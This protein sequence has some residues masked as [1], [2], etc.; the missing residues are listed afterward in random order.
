MKTTLTL[1][2]LAAFSTL[3][4]ADIF[5]S[6]Y[7]ANRIR[8]FDS[9]GADMGTFASISR[10]LGLRY[11]P[12]GTFYVASVSTNRVLE[13]NTKGQTIRTIGAG[14]PITAPISLAFDATVLY[15]SSLAT[16]QILKYSRSNG[17]YLGALAT[18]GPLDGPH[19]LAV[20]SAGNIVVA[21]MNNHSVLRYSN[22]GTLLGMYT[23]EQLD[24]P[25]GVATDASGKVYV[26]SLGGNKIFSLDNTLNVII[27]DAALAGPNDMLISGSNLYVNSGQDHSIRMYDLRTGLFTSNFVGPNGVKE[28]VGIAVPEPKSLVILIIAILSLK[29]RKQL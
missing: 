1:L 29:N 12:T 10:P 6:E 15:V 25:F 23:H 3:C 8:R 4:Q 20:D 18:A 16:N 28:P 2:A 26:S 19:G 7:S 22:S 11:S 13:L 5:V 21:S 17:L 9:T 24:K 27:D 14:S